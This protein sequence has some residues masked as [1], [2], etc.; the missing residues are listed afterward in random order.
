MVQEKLRTFD[1][2]KKKE[3]SGGFVT[4]QEVKKVSGRVN[5]FD[6]GGAGSGLGSGTQFRMNKS[7]CFILGQVS[8]LT[9]H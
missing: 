7:K 8:T 3:E 1:R 4:E 9:D 2:Q 6:R 5:S